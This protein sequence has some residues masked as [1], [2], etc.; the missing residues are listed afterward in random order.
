MLKGFPNVSRWVDTGDVLQNALMRLLR[1]LQQLQPESMRALY[2]LAAEHIRREL[3]DLARHF[4]GPEGVGANHHSSRGS[5]TGQTVAWEPVAPADCP[6]ELDR[7]YHFHQEVEKLPSSHREVVSLI[8]YHGWTQADVASLFQVT[9]RTIR[10]R[11]QEALLT[12][13]EA[14]RGRMP[15][16]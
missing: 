5:E 2:N 16:N 15:T 9:E 1:T 8:F 10:R 11:W 7:W 4:Y 13:R 3:I 6:D 12:L 14:L